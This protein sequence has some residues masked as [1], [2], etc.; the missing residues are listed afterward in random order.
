MRFALNR[1][2][3]GSV[4]PSFAFTMP[5]ELRL[6]LPGWPADCHAAF[7][8]SSLAFGS[9]V[10]ICSTNSSLPFSRLRLSA[11]GILRRKRGLA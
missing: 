6:I 3:V 5:M 7:T 2:R 11:I 9:L 10:K 4:R 8:V 1:E